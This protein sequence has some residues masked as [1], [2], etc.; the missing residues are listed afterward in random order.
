MAEMTEEDMLKI[1]YFVIKHRYPEL[2]LRNDY[3]D[4]VQE[5]RINILKQFRRFKEG[6]IP[7]LGK[8]HKASTFCYC[9]SRWA[10]QK[11]L[12]KKQ[13]K[14]AGVDFISDLGAIDCTQKEEEVEKGFSTKYENKELV[15]L[16]LFDYLQPPNYKRKVIKALGF[17]YR[18]GLYPWKEKH[19]LRETSN[20]LGLKSAERVRQIEREVILAL[21]NILENYAMHEERMGVTK[22]DL[23]NSPR[24]LDQTKLRL[25][26]VETRGNKRNF[27]K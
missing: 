2:A 5:C 6:K 14:E 8:D 7:N 4:I 22:Q 26:E 18:V 27:L 15:D 24:S 13:P 11:Y 10:I 20:F 9:C 21:R 25:D 3:H 23:E 16:L 12:S 19:T 17:R 1:P